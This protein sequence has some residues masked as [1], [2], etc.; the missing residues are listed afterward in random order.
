VTIVDTQANMEQVKSSYDESSSLSVAHQKNM[1]VYTPS[2]KPRKSALGKLKRDKKSRSASFSDSE[3][4]FLSYYP[5]YENN[6]S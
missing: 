5:Y 3:V 4:L 1:P 6:L 2:K